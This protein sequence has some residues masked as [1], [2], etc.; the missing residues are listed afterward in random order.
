MNKKE[1]GKEEVGITNFIKKAANPGV[2]LM[3]I[4]FKIA[5]IVSFILLDLF[6][7]KETFVYLIV[8]LLGSADFWVTKN[9]SGRILAGLRWWNEVKE[10]GEEVWIFESKN[11]SKRYCFLIYL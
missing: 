5:A 7:D 11:E 2:C 9:I 4:G 10:N 6:T 3:T 8:I 1:E